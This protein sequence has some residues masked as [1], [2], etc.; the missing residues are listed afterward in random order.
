MLT[1]SARKKF[2]FQVEPSDR[3]L[4]AIGMVAVTWTAIEFMVT[5][6]VHALTDT[7]SAERK[8]FDSTR[9]MDLRLD[10][11]DELVRQKI[12]EPWQNTL[13]GLVN[14]ARHVKDMRDKIIHG[15]WGGKQNDPKLPDSGTEAH[16]AFRFGK[17][18]APFSW[19]LNYGDI[20]KV[21][22]RIDT[23]QLN[24]FE[25]CFEAAEVKPGET[26]VFSD[27]LKRISRT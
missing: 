26:F 15:M 12:I 21:A 24:L 8:A 18:H 19:Q 27:A 14:E 13:R 4:W 16:G 6:Q 2:K 20:L 10:Q 9:S 25:F 17:P 22:L 23:L 3:Q 7:G 11:W 1:T 5:T